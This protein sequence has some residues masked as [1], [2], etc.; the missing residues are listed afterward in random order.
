LTGGLGNSVIATMEF[1]PCISDIFSGIG[2]QG[3][4]IALVG[5]PPTAGRMCGNFSRDRRVSCSNNV[6][7]FMTGSPLGKWRYR[8]SRPGSRRQCACR[9]LVSRGLIGLSRAPSGSPLRQEVDI[10]RT[11]GCLRRGSA[12]C[13]APR[14][15]RRWHPIGQDEDVDGTPIAGRRD[16]ARA[17]TRNRT[18]R[19]RSP[20]PGSLPGRPRDR[21]S[22]APPRSGA[23]NNPGGSLLTVPACRFP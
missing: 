11:A 2:A 16:R 1:W 10:D 4:A 13:P 14:L 9:H 23:I 7:R 18:G 22:C 15:W 5:E 21:R 20:Q 8:T 19:R 17:A 3:A 12:R 6:S